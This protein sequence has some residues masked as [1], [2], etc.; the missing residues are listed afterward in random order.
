[1]RILLSTTL[2]FGGM[3]ICCGAEFERPVRLQ[4]AG[5]PI[6]VESPGYAAPC[7]ADLDGDGKKELL[8][9]QF[10]GGKIKVYK[11]LSDGKYAAGS[12]LKAD[13]IDAEIPGVW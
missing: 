1:M 4:A 9:G 6:Q 7:V 12:W 11:E 8:V 5:E 2:W 3:V 10:N 13:G